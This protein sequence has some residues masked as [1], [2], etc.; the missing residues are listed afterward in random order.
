MFDLYEA[1]G[2]ASGNSCQLNINIGKLRYFIGHLSFQRAMAF[3]GCVQLLEISMGPEAS[4][5]DR[6]T[7]R[8]L[9]EPVWRVPETGLSRLHLGGSHV[10]Y[11][12]Q[13]PFKKECPLS[14]F[15]QQ[16]FLWQQLVWKYQVQ[17]QLFGGYQLALISTRGKGLRMWYPVDPARR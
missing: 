17:Q 11:L 6:A 13:I 15:Q 7:A 14:F 9:R 4:L 3:C 12:W 2:I 10:G 8:Q 5:K 16:C 1:T